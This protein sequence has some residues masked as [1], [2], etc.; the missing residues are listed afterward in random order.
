EAA[1]K[2]AARARLALSRLL[3]E[4]DPRPVVALVARD[5]DPA[6]YVRWLEGA[7]ARVRILPSGAAG[8]EALLADALV[9]SSGP[10]DIH[11]ATYGEPVRVALGGAPSAARDRHDA[12]LLRQAVGLGLP[13]LGV[14]AGHQLLNIACGGTLYQDI[15][16]DGAGD[17]AHATEQHGVATVRDTAI[18]RLCGGR[19]EVHSRHHQAI[20]RLGRGLRP[21]AWS[22]DGLVEAVEHP[23]SRF[24]VGVQWQPQDQASELGAALA[25]ALVEAAA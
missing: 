19:V 21:T 1:R 4:D 11:P 15:A 22:P 13:V 16:D 14:C 7:G 2:R 6:P 9:V 3:A 8:G 24:A 17:A 23:G 10:T 18:R 12:L 5:D 20:R 25:E